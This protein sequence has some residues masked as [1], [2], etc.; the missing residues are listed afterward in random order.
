[1]YDILL[2][3]YYK[4][5]EKKVTIQKY[6]ISDTV[7]LSV[8]RTQKFKTN[9]LTVKLIVPL[10]ESTASFYSLLC[11]VIKQGTASYPSLAALS[12]ESQNLYALIHQVRTFKS[13][14]YQIIEFSVDYLDA[15][16]IPDNCDVA[17]GAL[18]ILE[19]LLYHPLLC[20]G[21]FCP[22]YVEREKQSLCDS[23]Q[24]KMNNKSVFAMHRLIETMCR[25]EAYGVHAEGDIPLI[26]TITPQSLYDAYCK[27]LCTA[28]IEVFYVGNGDMECLTEA[29]RKIFASHP[30]S[31][32]LP[33]RADIQTK[34]PGCRFTEVVETFPVQQSKLCMGFRL[35]CSL[36]D[37][38]WSAALVFCE[39]FGASPQSKLF[40][41]IREKLSL[42]Y[43]CN[44][45]TIATNGIM[46]VQSAIDQENR[47]VVQSE[48]LNMLGEMQ[49]GK[50][51]SE[52][53]DAAKRSLI[54]TILE[55]QDSAAAMEN[56]YF[57]HNLYGI[58]IDIEEQ[59]RRIQNVTRQDVIT[60]AKAVAS[61]TLYFLKGS[62]SEK[63]NINEEGEEAECNEYAE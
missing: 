7:D 25:D 16:F 59:I 27:L 38:N 41:Q 44:A 62:L 32:T 58:H 63:E 54:N 35:N 12:K 51:S 5:S 8:I 26:Q 50:F 22:E 57:I 29:L 28:K 34:Q 3:F 24:A 33:P 37:P 21:A 53:L 52:D 18:H 56:W 10:Q 13:G 23:I 15:A 4:Q 61:D 55:N 6:S 31:N 42:C 43:Y 1:M 47:P 39:I 14:C 36:S 19:E 30:A 40:M 20:N 17:A 11:R 46:I 49:S 60:A 48:I 2:S 45:G 9:V